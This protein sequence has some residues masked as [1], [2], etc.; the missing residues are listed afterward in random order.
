MINIYNLIGYILISIPFIGI[1]IVMYNI[2]GIDG[3]KVFLIILV[4]VGMI[5]LI[6]GTGCYLINK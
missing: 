2:D 3:L 4:I 6:V 5:G 1:G